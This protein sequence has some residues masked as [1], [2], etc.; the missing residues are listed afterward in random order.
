[1]IVPSV[2]K[3]GAG[4]IALAAAVVVGVAVRPTPESSV[5]ALRAG[6]EKTEAARPGGPVNPQV[7]EAR[8]KLDQ[9][10]R[11]NQADAAAPAAPA[12]VA[13]PAAPVEAAAALAPS[14][15]SSPLPRQTLALAPAPAPTDGG[16]TAITRSVGAARPAAPAL[17]VAPAASA[18]ASGETDELCDRAG[19]ELE[20]GAVASARLLLTR[21]V[22]AGAPRALHM[23]AETYDPQALK[24][25]GLRAS[26]DAGKARDLYARAAAAGSSDSARRLAALPK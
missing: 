22:R 4:M 1:M 24:E 6:D 2:I 18:E 3:A 7:V 19:R 16:Q 21:A 8:R 25:R 5:A 13:Q 23:L 17:A 20:D 9:A 11:A 14:P 26:A 10:L 12:P 15:V